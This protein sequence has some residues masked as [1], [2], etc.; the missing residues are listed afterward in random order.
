MSSNRQDS[1]TW[2]NQCS[3]AAEARRVGKMPFRLTV[4]EITT[5]M[6]KP[7][8]PLA[9]S[10]G[11]A[12]HSSRDCRYISLPQYLPTPRSFRA[13]PLRPLL[14]SRRPDYNLALRTNATTDD[15]C[16]VTL[17]SSRILPANRWSGDSRPQ[18]LCAVA[19]FSAPVGTSRHLRSQHGPVLKLC[20]PG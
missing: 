12:P 5:G 15:D 8:S 18:S 13:S 14:T 9:Y 11:P 6:P 2:R 7:V 1:A 10:Q 3:I 17:N 19:E 20:G 16:W 4:K